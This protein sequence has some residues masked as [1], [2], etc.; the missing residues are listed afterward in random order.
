MTTHGKAGARVADGLREA[1]LAGAYAPGERIRQEELAEQ[2]RASR[3][4]VREA[5]RIL[6]AEGLVRLV[7][8]AGAWVSTL[9]LAECVELYQIRERIEPLLL[10]ASIPNLAPADTDTLEDL[11]ERMA[12]SSDPEVFITLDRRFHLATYAA[13]QTVMLGSTTKQLW[14]RTQHYRR[15]FVTSGNVQG[16]DSAHLDHR[17][18]ISAIRRGDAE[19]AGDVLARHIRRTRVELSGRPELFEH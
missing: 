15:A 6:E 8:N 1:I 12:R 11:V 19:E 16:M 14:N 17:L 18:M 10:R 7:A 3:V 13:A 5:L 2:Y 4:P 9:E